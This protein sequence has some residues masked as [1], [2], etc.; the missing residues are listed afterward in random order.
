MHTSSLLVYS[1]CIGLRVLS[2][3][4]AQKIIDSSR[5]WAD[6]KRGGVLRAMSNPFAEAFPQAL[7]NVAHMFLDSDAETGDSTQVIDND[8]LVAQIMAE[9]NPGLPDDEVESLLQQPIAPP[10][11]VQCHQPRGMPGNQRGV[12]MMGS[13]MTATATQAYAM[14]DSRNKEVGQKLSSTEKKIKSVE[15]HWEA[16][17]MKEGINA[18]ACPRFLQ[19]DDKEYDLVKMRS[20]MQFLDTADVTLSQIETGLLFIQHYLNRD[21]EAFNKPKVTGAVKAD[22]AIKCIYEKHK[23]TKATRAMEEGED[24]QADLD[25]RIS[26]EQMDGMMRE[27]F[28]PKYKG[29]AAMSELARIQTAAEIRH[30]HT[31][32][33]RGDNIRG[34][35]A[36]MAF[37]RQARGIGP[38]RN[39]MEID[40]L[41][42]N[43]GKQNQQGKFMYTSMAPHMNPLFD[44]VG[45]QGKRRKLESTMT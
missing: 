39:G 43:K 35:T 27:C 16:F 40:Y 9:H 44:T 11:N 37:T 15:K 8:L 42:T 36:C 1:T 19:H 12:N 21:C 18:S 13:P 30:S 22:F 32:G 41:I 45:L 17:C 2:C 28:S 7:H 38:T 4:I 26:E 5:L 25:V 31:T 6:H 33:E 3:G 23:R 10:Q 34:Y 20:F 29:V 14:L 24:I